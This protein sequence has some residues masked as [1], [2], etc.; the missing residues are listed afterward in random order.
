MQDRD[1]RANIVS[2]LVSPAKQTLYDRLAGTAVERAAQ[3]A[4]R[5]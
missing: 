1:A 3:V 5:G 2:L 4:A